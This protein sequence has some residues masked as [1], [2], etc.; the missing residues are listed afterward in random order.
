MIRGQIW[1]TCFVLLSPGCFGSTCSSFSTTRTLHLLENI[2]LGSI[3]TQ[4]ALE[5]GVLDRENRAAV[6]TVEQGM[7][8]LFAI[9]RHLRDTVDCALEQLQR[10]GQV[11]RMQ[12]TAVLFAV[13]ASEDLQEKRKYLALASAA[14]TGS[15][16]S[17]YYQA[18]ANIELYRLGHSVGQTTAA[19]ERLSRAFRLMLDGKMLEHEYVVAREYIRGL[20]LSEH[21]DSDDLQ[22]FLAVQFPWLAGTKLYDQLVSKPWRGTELDPYFV[23]HPRPPVEGLISTRTAT[24]Y[25]ELLGIQNGK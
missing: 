11:Q 10:S 18:L 4:S 24:R 3:E 12:R 21:G 14:T 9:R 20:L 23:P 7:L 19:L 8:Q 25:R 16:E 1:V 5:S 13:G 6:Y 22:E 17:N 2:A 15:D